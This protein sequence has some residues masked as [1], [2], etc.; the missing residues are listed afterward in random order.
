MLEN[1]I[2]IIS[3][4][5]A[6]NILSIDLQKIDSAIC[7]YFIVCSANSSTHSKS[8]EKKITKKIS[9][10]FGEKPYSIE[11]AQVG[12][13]ILLD[14]YDIIVHIFLEK[15]RDYYNIEDFW[16]DGKITKYN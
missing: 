12:S 9:Q 15:T 6:K 11:G 3:D 4:A 1:I 10:D 7:K 16:G 8:I 5:K 2:D 13:W 14:Y